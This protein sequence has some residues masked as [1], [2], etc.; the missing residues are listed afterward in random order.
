MVNGPLGAEIEGTMQKG[1]NSR[2]IGTTAGRPDIV[3]ASSRGRA[4]TF[5][6]IWKWTHILHDEGY[7]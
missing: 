7:L 5:L 4:A 1:T 2:E 6:K 3:N